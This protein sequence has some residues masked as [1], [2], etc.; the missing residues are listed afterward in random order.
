M[1]Q[2]LVFVNHL[3]A[4]HE[5]LYSILEKDEEAAKDE[6]WKLHDNQFPSDEKSDWQIT[7]FEVTFTVQPQYV[8][9]VDRE[10]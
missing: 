5:H 8:A 2:F 6:V 1:K 10:T 9:R 4:D 7:A 3:F